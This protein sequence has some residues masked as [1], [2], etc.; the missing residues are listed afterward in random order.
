MISTLLKKG[1]KACV[2][3]CKSIWP[4]WSGGLP[5]IPSVLWA[6]LCL[7]SVSLRL[8]HGH[9]LIVYLL[10]VKLRVKSEVNYA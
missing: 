8:V 10:W 6:R 3:F 7:A 5:A 4:S 2:V 1:C 9:P